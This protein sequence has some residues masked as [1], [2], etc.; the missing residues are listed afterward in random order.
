MDC[1]LT[2]LFFWASD[3]TAANDP[4]EPPALQ[5]LQCL[6]NIYHFSVIRYSSE[7]LAVCMRL[8]CHVFS[9]ANSGTRLARLVLAEAETGVSSSS[10]TGSAAEELL[11]DAH[12]I[13][14]SF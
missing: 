2:L 11:Q 3:D 10:L 1:Y 6:Q 8:A 7:H 5:A 4:V 13:A 12:S 9:V 14:N